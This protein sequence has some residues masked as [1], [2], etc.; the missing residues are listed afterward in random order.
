MIECLTKTNCSIVVF[1]VVTLSLFHFKIG[2]FHFGAHS[3]LGKGVVLWTL[4]ANINGKPDIE[5][6]AGS[7]NYTFL[8]LRAS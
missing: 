3:L 1:S 6:I 8:V 7:N 5:V 4:D 2:Y